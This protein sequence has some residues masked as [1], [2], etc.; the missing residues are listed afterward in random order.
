M[1]LLARLQ[2]ALPLIILAFTIAGPS[3]S[4]APIITF[5]VQD[6]TTA[7]PLQGATILLLGAQSITQDTSSNGIASIAI[8]F[9][10][11]QITVGKPQCTPIGPQQFVV[12]ETAPPQI[13]VKLQCSPSGSPPLENPTLQTDNTTY[14]QG[15]VLSWQ[16]AGF[17]PGAYVR[18]CLGSVCGGIAQSNSIGQANGAFVISAQLTGTQTFSVTNTNTGASVQDQITISS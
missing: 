13:T 12:D 4:T 9:G 7:Q 14:H 15:D 10:N 3:Q 11:Y 5:Y 1:I 16:T 17:A 2:A 8:Q 18:P 6:Y